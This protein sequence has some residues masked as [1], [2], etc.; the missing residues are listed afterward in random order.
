MSASREG[1]PPFSVIVPVKD[2]AEEIAACLEALLH[3]T[4]P[5]EAYEIVVVDDGSCDRTP[6]IVGGFQER[7]VRLIRLPKTEGRIVARAKGVLEARFPRVVLIDSRVIADSTLLLEFARGGA[8]PIIGRIRHED[9]P[10]WVGRFFYRLKRW[11][12]HPYL[13]E[14]FDPVR[15]SGPEELGRRVPVGMGIFC[16]D[17][18]DYLSAIPEVHHRFVHDDTRMFESLLAR[19]PIWKLAG[20]AGTYRQ[21]EDWGSVWRHLYDRGRRFSE[22]HIAKR[23][24]VRL[25]WW[26]MLL[27]LSGWLRLALALP[28]WA[29]VALLGASAVLVGA[30]A[31]KLGAVLRGLG[32]GI[33]FVGSG[34]VLSIPFLLGVIRDRPVEALLVTLVPWLL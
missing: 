2:G 8:A 1:S 30:A 10:G 26:L 13:D 7:G 17:R 15:L 20:P 33:R 28:G 31:W 32:E 11:Y 24:P 29:L 27:I 3:Q 18:E 4:Y 9:G 23:F 34:I 16:C 25:G 22:Y 19:K 5:C 21:R 6:E 14:S 12:Y